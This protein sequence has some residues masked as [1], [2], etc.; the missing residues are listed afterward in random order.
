MTQYLIFVMAHANVV[1]FVSSPN[2]APPSAASLVAHMPFIHGG[3]VVLP[4][5]IL[6]DLYSLGLEATTKVAEGA[7]LVMFA[8]A[9]LKVE[10]GNALVAA[11]MKLTTAYGS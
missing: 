8:G 1:N 7:S 10:I 4:P 11:G 9:P 3:M 6:E 2:P 5:S